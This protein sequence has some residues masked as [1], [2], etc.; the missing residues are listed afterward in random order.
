MNKRMLTIACLAAAIG[1]IPAQT[2]AEDLKLGVVPLENKQVMFKQF[3]PLCDYLSKELGANV[4][5]VVGKDYQGAMD[6]LGQNNVQIAYLTPTVFPKCKVQNPDSGI[7]PVV[8]FKEAG[9]GTYRSC[10]IVPADSKITA[11]GEIKGKK[12]A[13]GS[14]DSTGS[15][16]MPRA[17]LAAQGIGIDNITKAYLGSHSKVANAV[18]A[19]EYDAGG[20]KDSVA[21]QFAA[22]KKV[23]II[24]TSDSIPEFP[25]CVNKNVSAELESKIKAAFIKLDGKDEASKKILTSI[26]PKYSGV[27]PAAD[28]DYNVIREM[29]K[30]L[31]GDEFYKK[32]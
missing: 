9:A 14:E 32:K 19:G 25:I 3:Q 24:A 20:V 26:N 2:K 17:M 27:E 18:G 1:F 13:F 12:F 7:R 29:I 4:T 31:Y 28:A 23:K 5:L 10:I 21:D 8:R 6:D 15:H 16:L 11:I 22:E 30:K